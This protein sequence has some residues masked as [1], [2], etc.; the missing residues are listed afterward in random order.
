MELQ[1]T[2]N[3]LFARRFGPPGRVRYSYSLTDWAKEPR[4]REAWDR[5]VKE[6]NLVQSPFVSESTVE[7]VFSFADGAVLQTWPM[8]LRYVKRLIQV[9]T[10]DRG[11]CGK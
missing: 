7:R 6:Y 2:C 1:V 5:I 10:A 11:T 9:Q 3:Q 4:N 8:A